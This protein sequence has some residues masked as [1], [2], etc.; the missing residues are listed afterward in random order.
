MVVVVVVEGCGSSLT[1]VLA[2]VISTPELQPA[3]QLNHPETTFK[4]P[5]QP[6][7]TENTKNRKYANFETHQL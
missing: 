3:H 4:L 6:Q 2:R 5:R 7:P 1:Q